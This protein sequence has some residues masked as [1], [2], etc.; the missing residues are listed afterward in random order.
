MSAENQSFHDIERE[1]DNI[2]F[3]EDGILDLINLVDQAI[4][5]A[6]KNNNDTRTNTCLNHLMQTKEKELSD[7]KSAKQNMREKKLRFEV[8]IDNF[9]EDLRMFCE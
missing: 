3:S 1:L 2:N 7:L 9:R 4:T 8:V 6:A 5:L